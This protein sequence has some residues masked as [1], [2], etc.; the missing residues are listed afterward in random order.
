MATVTAT[1]GAAVP[2]RRVGRDR[3]VARGSLAL[4]GR[5]RRDGRARPAPDEA[6]RAIDAAERAMREPLPRL[7]AGR[8]PRARLDADR[9]AKRGARRARSRPRPA[10]RS[11]TARIEAARAVNTYGLSAG[12]ARRLSGDIVPIHGNAARRRAT[13]PGRCACRSGSSARSRRS[14]SRSTSSRT[15]SR[16]RW[17]PAARSSSSRRARRPS[18][19]LRL[20]AI[21]EEAGLPAGWLSVLPGKASEIGDVLTEDERVRM[22]TFTGSSEVGWGIR[23]RAFRKKVALELGN[24][25]PVL[26]EADADLDLA[27]SKVATHAF[28]FAGQTCVSVQR[29]Y[30]RREVF[31]DFV[32]RL[33]PK[34]EALQ[35]GRSG[36]RRRPTSGPVIDRDEPRARRSSGSTRRRQAARRCSSGGVEENGVIRPTVLTDVTPEMNVCRQEIFG[37]GVLAHPVR[38]ARRGLRAR[39]RHRVRASVRDLHALDRAGDQGDRARSSSAA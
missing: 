30:V 29:V 19:A 33:V 20:A 4:L 32:A 17:P 11:R 28:S 13:S 12:E 6:R 3:R 8:H 26:V 37:P 25:S 16:R 15:S 18:R 27:S 9:G 38:L 10:S 14:T 1:T 2:R 23:Q 5:R 24:A 31:D 39:E 21:C 7:A 36:G 35:G 34:V 22:I